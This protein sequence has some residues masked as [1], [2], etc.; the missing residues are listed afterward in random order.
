MLAQWFFSFLMHV[1]NIVLFFYCYLFI[2]TYSYF[3]NAVCLTIFKN[4]NLNFFKILF[5]KLTVSSRI[6]CPVCSSWSFSSM[7]LVF[8]MSNDS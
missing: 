6:E 7:L 5:P 3:M 1:S 8:L 4:S 2:A